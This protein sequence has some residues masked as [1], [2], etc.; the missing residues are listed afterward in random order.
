MTIAHRLARRQEDCVATRQLREA[1]LTERQIAGLV[2]RGVLTRVVRSVYMLGPPPLR[3][4]QLRWVALLAAGNDA[5]LSHRT[6]AEVRRM[7]RPAL[8][9]AFVTV[10]G[11]RRERTIRTEVIIEETGRRGMIRIHHTR[12]KLSAELVDRLRVTSPGRTLVGIAGADGFSLAR[13]AWREGDYLGLL[14]GGDVLGALGRGIKGSRL[15]R[16]LWRTVPIVQGVGRRTE[17]P[18]EFLLL[19]AMREI[20]LPEPLVNVPMHLEGQRPR[21]DF[22]FALVNGIVETDGGIHDTPARRAEDEAREALLRRH[23]QQVFR[24]RNEDIEADAIAA[25]RGVEAFLATLV[26]TEGLQ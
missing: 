12:A 21:P 6:A 10:A 22:R 19:E 23:G 5:T 24:V 3:H 16:L 15:V 11:R 18:A 9:R 25:A 17:T 14:R 1:G 7:L 13:A 4:R 20:G 26:A 8:G 2:R